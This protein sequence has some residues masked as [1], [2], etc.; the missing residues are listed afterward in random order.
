[1]ATSDL[2]A[3][4]EKLRFSMGSQMN[5]CGVDDNVDILPA[6][7]GEALCLFH[8]ISSLS[9]IQEDVNRLHVLMASEI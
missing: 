5:S 1:M 2:A 7:N 3:L 6:L 9:T 8:V 4:F